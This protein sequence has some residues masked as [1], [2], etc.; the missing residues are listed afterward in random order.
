M[1]DDSP[2]PLASNPR[3]I[4]PGEIGARYHDPSLP[5]I[6]EHRAPGS[7]V[8][9]LD[10]EEEVDIVRLGEDD[11]TAGELLSLEVFKKLLSALA[12]FGLLI[13]LSYAIPIPWA[14][15]WRADEDYI[16]FW[17]IIGRELLGQGEAA[18]A[19]AEEAARMAE[20]ANKAV[21]LEDNGPVADRQP[22]TPPP[23]GDEPIVYPEYVAHELDPDPAAIEQLL[24]NPE[25]LAPYY[26][27]L[28]RTDI[29][30]AGAVTRAGH[31]GD[32]VLGMDGIT[33]AI[34]RR[35]QA[36]FGDAGH[37]F[38]ALKQYDASYQQQNVRF[39]EA[40]NVRWN[41]CFIR[42]RCMDDGRYGYGGV[43]VWSSGGAQS[44][45]G[46]AREGPV[47]LSVSRFELWYQKQYKGGKIRLRVD[48]GNEQI[49]DTALPLPE[50]VDSLPPD[51]RPA[52]V[53]A[54]ALVTV[55]DGPHELEVR[56]IGGGSVRAFGV[57]LERD[58][59][60]VTWDGMALIGAFTSRMSEFDPEHLSSQLDHRG[61]DLLV[62]TFGGND[63]TREK[64]D[65][66]KTMDPYLEDYGKVIELFRAARPEAA[67][68]IMGPVDHGQRDNGYIASRE[69]VARMTEAQRQVALDHGC[70]FSDTLA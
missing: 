26:E 63:M 29:G 21:E 42:N 10:V 20:L 41:S 68:L 66:R 60:G 37:G 36:R 51:Q 2:E 17:N 56:A 15:P 47:G 3:E 12:T 61:L 54:W 24:D 52:A 62:F 4:K 59:P 38:H 28:T 69:I 31:W 46:T 55:P 53:D 32:S 27:A 9:L 65:L 48:G 67:C 45:Y 34:R 58:G 13:G 35:M 49:I 44:E 70:A 16:P 33:S 8:G 7:H 30:Y 19:E 39:S 57:V 6:G 40:G 64:S 22:V 18:E 23:T 50:G 25:A 11:D 5:P 14:Q 43:T 1:S